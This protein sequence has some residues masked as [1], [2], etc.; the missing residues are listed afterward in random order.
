MRLEVGRPDAVEADED[1]CALEEVGAVR[2]EVGVVGWG[3]GA[4]KGDEDDDY[5]NGQERNERVW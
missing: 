5:W 4:G 1:G 2:E 3:C